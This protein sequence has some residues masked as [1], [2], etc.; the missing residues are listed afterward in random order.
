V[1]S[2]RKMT[3][4]KDVLIVQEFKRELER[5]MTPVPTGPG[6]LNL[7]QGHGYLSDWTRERWETAEIELAQSR[8]WPRAP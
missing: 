6:L 1:V 3:L 8:V 2:E 4:S 5:I 7:V